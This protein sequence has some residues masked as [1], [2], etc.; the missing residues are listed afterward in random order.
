MNPVG[1]VDLD[2]SIERIACC[3]FTEE[4]VAGRTLCTMFAVGI[5]LLDAKLLNSSLRLVIGCSVTVHEVIDSGTGVFEVCVA[6]G[7]VE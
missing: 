7:R 2:S 6:L 1:L 4:A 5:G 3:K